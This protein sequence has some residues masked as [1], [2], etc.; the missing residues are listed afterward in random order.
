MTRLV[1][2]ASLALL[3]AACGGPGAQPTLPQTPDPSGPGQ[4]PSVGSI[5]SCSLLS[6]G[7]IE[8]ATGQRVVDRQLSAL[9][10]DVFPSI[11]DIELDGG[12][13]LTV[14][15]RSSGGR[16]MYEDSFEPFIGDGEGLDEAV[17]GL[18]D[19]AARSGDDVLMVLDDDVLFEVQYFEFGRRDELA[20][21]RYLAE[22]IVAKLACLAAGC[23]G[24][25]PPPLA[26]APAFDACALLTA[27]EIED[28]TGYAVL[29]TEPAGGA[30]RDAGCTW[31]VD[32]DPS[33]PGLYSIRLEVMASGG[34]DQFDFL[35]QAYDPP[36][37]H[38]P[39]IGDD[40]ITTA[41]IP[42]GAIYV[43]AG[44]RL[45]TLAFSLPLSVDDPYSLVLP[46]LGPALERLGS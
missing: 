6:D 27:E 16:S 23:T 31:A 34:Q 40:A 5:D 19:K 2:S 32:A 39:G 36:L 1:L 7:E 9:R 13:S 8:A 22:I 3:L 10:P 25:T 37:E 29:D 35:A 46:L 12:G 11:C 42:D 30:G 20:I 44:D 38:V 43:L 24:F 45:V 21:V 4:S 15:V 17:L 14:S 28:A 26:T 41:T 33:L 18:G